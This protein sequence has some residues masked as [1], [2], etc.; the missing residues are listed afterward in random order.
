MTLNAHLNRVKPSSFCSLA[1]HF[2]LQVVHDL[3]V[4][5]AVE[6][7]EESEHSLLELKSVPVIACIATRIDIVAFIDAMHLMQLSYDVHN[8]ELVAYD[9]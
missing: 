6:V 9:C 5:L 7:L 3:E 2:R 1:Q 4:A 8:L